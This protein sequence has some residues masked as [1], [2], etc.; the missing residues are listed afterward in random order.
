LLFP[1]VNSSWLLVSRILHQTKSRW[2]SAFFS[3]SLCAATY[4]FRHSFKQYCALDKP[5]SGSQCT[6]KTPSNTSMNRSKS[7]NHRHANGCEVGGSQA[8]TNTWSSGVACRLL[9]ADDFTDQESLYNIRTVDRDHRLNETWLG[10]LQAAEVRSS[11]Q[12]VRHEGKGVDVG[13]TRSEILYFASR[14]H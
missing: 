3:D 9:T 12:R 2:N 11:S 4:Q 8:N 13:A 7:S 14:H 1:F 10:A 5:K 6:N